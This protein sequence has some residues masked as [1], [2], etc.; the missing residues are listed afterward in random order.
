MLRNSVFDV[1]TC[2]FI[3]GFAHV[4]KPAGTYF[5]RNRGHPPLGRLGLGDGGLRGATL[6]VALISFACCVLVKD[7][8]DIIVLLDCKIYFFCGGFTLG[9]W[10]YSVTI[11]RRKIYFTV[12]EGDYNLKG[13]RFS[14]ELF[15]CTQRKFY[16][17]RWLKLGV[18]YTWRPFTEDNRLS[19]S[20]K[21][22]FLVTW[23]LN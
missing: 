9:N 10:C 15:L 7:I 16:C 13:Y 20:R 1:N 18:V 8:Q 23:N 6:S 12:Y 11:H 3:T 5:R 19:T 21:K 17:L 22:S 14:S 4:F 2:S